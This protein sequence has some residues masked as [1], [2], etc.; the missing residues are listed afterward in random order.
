MNG[1]HVLVVDDDPDIVEVV[2]LV[3]EMSGYRVSRASDGRGAL[4]VLE[5]GLPQL[6]LL[7]MRMPVMDGWAF[8]RELRARYGHRVPVIV[9]TAAEDARLRAREV[10]AE[11]VLCKPFDVDALLAAVLRHVSGP[12][13][14]APQAPP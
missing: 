11:D 2:A 5:H 1:A 6:I 4:R 7:D 8:A 13:A 9:M 10:E 14:H 3:L 12:Q